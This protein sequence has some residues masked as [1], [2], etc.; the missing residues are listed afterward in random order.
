MKDAQELRR[1]FEG[2]RFV[3]LAGIEIDSVS[4]GAASCSVILEEKHMNALGSPQ[5]GL[6]Y[7]LAD[8]AFAAASNAGGDPTVTIGGNIHYIGA[9]KG[10]R[11]TALALEKSPGG[12]RVCV[13]EVTVSDDT[14][15]VVALA[16]FTGYVKKRA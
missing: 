14:G 8:F 15:A 2:D 13:Y 7:T 4:E 1:Y 3:A 9:S 12:K 10:K 6:I 16:S 11:L 5:G